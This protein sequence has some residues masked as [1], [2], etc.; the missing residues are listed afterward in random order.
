MLTLYV[1]TFG[2]HFLSARLTLE[3]SKGNEERRLLVVTT[4]SRP[5]ENISNTFFK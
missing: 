1:R 4:V 3:I 5:K 2:S